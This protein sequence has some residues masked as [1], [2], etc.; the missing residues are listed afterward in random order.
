MRVLSK[1][2]MLAIEGGDFN[3]TF[4]NAITKAFSVFFEIGQ[5]VGSAIRRGMEHQK[6]PL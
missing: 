6:C 4:I 2:E 1:K 5:S 3:S